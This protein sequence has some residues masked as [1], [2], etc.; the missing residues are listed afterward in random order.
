MLIYFHSATRAAHQRTHALVIHLWEVKGKLW[1]DGIEGALEVP[2]GAFALD[3]LG[4]SLVSEDV[5][6]EI[7]GE[8]TVLLLLPPRAEELQGLKVGEV[9]GC[10]TAT[11]SFACS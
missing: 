9:C 1:N 7:A 2:V 4:L 6:Q 3:D 11:A 10:E 8:P 5:L